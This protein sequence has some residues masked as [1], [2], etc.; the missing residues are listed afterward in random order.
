MSDVRVYSRIHKPISMLSS[1]YY[2]IIL[3]NDQILS[4]L[5]YL[6]AKNTTELKTWMEYIIL[7]PSKRKVVGHLFYYS[8][9]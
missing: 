9:S 1:T 7:I 4:Y 5:L 6:C 2:V 3:I 8:K